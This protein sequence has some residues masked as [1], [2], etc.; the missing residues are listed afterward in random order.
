MAAPACRTFIASCDAACFSARGPRGFTG[1]QGNTGPQGPTGAQGP[2]GS[3]GFI[4]STGPQGAQG[5]P[6]VTGPA[7]APQGSPGL[8][9]QRGATGATGP[10]GSPGVTG[11]QGPTGA[12]GSNGAQGAQGSPG[13]TGPT[14]PAGAQGPTGPQGGQGNQGSPGIT[15]PAGAAGSGQGPQG[16]PGVT[17][18]T[19][20]QGG[21]GSPGVTGPQGPTGP[22]GAQGVQGSPGVTG[23]AGAGGSGQG[24]QGSPGVT[25]ATGPQGVQGSPGVTGATGPQGAQGAQ[26]SPGVTGPAGAT[27]AQGPAGAAGAGGGAGGI[28]GP[29]Q[30]FDNAIAL[31]SGVGGTALKNSG[32]FIGIDSTLFGARG[33]QYAGEVSI[34]TGQTQIINWASGPDQA[35]FL[36]T[37]TSF[38]FT[39]PAASGPRA[40]ALRIKHVEPN[41]FATWPS[42]VKWADSWTPTLSIGSGAED[43]ILIEDRLGAYYARPFRNF[44]TGASGPFGVTG[45]IGATG[46]TGP[47]GAQGVTGPT[48]PQGQQGSPGLT[49]AAGAAGS[50][51]GPQG[52]PGVTGATG[53]TGP[54]GQQGSPGVT[55]PQ[56]AQGVQGSPGVTGPTGPTGPAGI[57]GS[58]GVTGPQGPTGSVGP[59]GSQGSPGVTGAQGVQGNQ[60]SPGVTGATGPQGSQG[61]QGVTGATG[62]TGPQGAQGSQGSPGV[63][64]STGPQGAQGS[65][66][67]TGQQG[68]TG[69]TGA[70]GAQGAQG[71]PGVTGPAG[72]NGSGGAGAGGGLTGPAQSSHQAIARWSGI[73]GTTLNNSS[74]FVSDGGEVFGARTIQFAG[75]VPVPTGITQVVNW[76]SGPYQTAFLGTSAD[77]S[78]VLTGPPTGPAWLTLRVI[79]AVANSNA[80]WVPTGIV[81]Q[82]SVTPTLSTASGAEDLVWFDARRTSP[83]GIKYY[84]AAALMFGTGGSGALGPTGPAGT[85]GATGPQGATG[86]AGATGV[87]GSQ[88]A[89]G[90]P[91]V[92]GPRGLG[93]LPAGT[94]VFSGAQMPTPS[95]IGNYGFTQLTTSYAN[96]VGGATA[97]LWGLAT[98][99]LQATGGAGVTGSQF[100]EV[101]L[102]FVIDGNAGPVI[103]SLQG[104]TAIREQVTVQHI[105]PA[106]GAGGHTGWV[107]FSKGTG[108]HQVYI[109]GNVVL[110]SLD[111]S[112]GATGPAGAQGAQGAAGSGGGNVIAPP[113]TTDHALARYT[114]ASGGIQDSTVLL[115]DLG[116]LQR[117]RTVEFFGEFLN[118]TTGQTMIIDLSKGQ[119]QYVPVGTTTWL[120]MTGPTGPGNYLL[121]VFHYNS[122]ATV[123]WPT[124][125]TGR[126]NWPSGIVDNLSTASGAVDLVSVYAVGITGP[127]NTQYYAQAGGAPFF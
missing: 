1:P 18:A 6:G 117:A 89:Q 25:G 41:T 21:Q 64:G 45:P 92:T 109:G 54:A 33:L 23:P 51:Q 36:G 3:P 123:N 86:P 100:N 65:P 19:G 40:L 62:P 120:I 99:E 60:G 124:G 27:G 70:Q 81:W 79:H 53:P 38:L 17:G 32:V 88:G 46:P 118:P 122:N 80:A 90:S 84:G 105:V 103:K 12:A 66:G 57:Q 72:A 85:N 42:S 96:V 83:T 11:P 114:G 121:R 55:G 10:Q 4:G 125:T 126:V 94:S 95:G 115:D 47:A 20:P 15:G 127:Q 69:P 52:S 61:A 71:S 24:P 22:Q 44:G 113:T 107:E 93:A 8:T 101:S 26:G 30:T 112:A 2:G 77:T 5:S 58:P 16:S 119:K 63:T 37:Q 104:G 59:Q 76:A 98:L 97:P 116:R 39:G 7:G 82:D 110:V 87:A 78:F 28:T 67:A 29:T 56:G 43:L 48:G 13:V 35:A 91:G 14:G 68:P 50:G 49:G 75:D 111:G 34:P 108:T 31:W 102:R 73:G 106:T 9:G 74:I